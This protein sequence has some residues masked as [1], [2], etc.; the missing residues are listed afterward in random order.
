MRHKAKK[1][2]QTALFIIAVG[3]WLFPSGH[4]TD[5]VETPGFSVNQS[6]GVVG[7]GWS[8]NI[9]A[10]SW[11]GS[12]IFS[13][14]EG[15]STGQKTIIG[16]SIVMML[17]FFAYRLVF[18]PVRR[19]KKNDKEQDSVRFDSTEF[20]TYI[21]EKVRQRTKELKLANE[22]LKE[23]LSG[24]PI[25]KGGLHH[26][27][28]HLNCLYGVSRLVEQPDISLGDVFQK[29]AHLLQEAY[30][31]P[32]E[33]SVRITFDGIKY[34]TDN[35]EKSESSQYVQIKIDNSYL[36]SIEVYCLSG[37][38]QNKERDFS[39]EED[40]L[41]NAIAGR[42]GSFAEQKRYAQ[43]LRLFQNL[44][45]QSSDSIFII[46]PQWGRLV[47]VNQT[48]CKMLGY[49]REELL[50]MTIKDIEE[51]ISDDSS[52]RQLVNDLHKSSF[53][54]KEG[55]HK[56]KDNTSFFV[57]TCLNCVTQKNEELI[58]ALAR[59]ITERKEA[60]QKQMRLI[61][62]LKESTYKVESINK[63]LKD[64]AYIISHDLKA[65]LRGIKTVTG[66][67]RDD[68][69]DKLDKDG[70]EQLDLLLSRVERMH[71]LIDGVLQYSRA[72]REESR[73]ELVNLNDLVPEAID[74]VLPP[75]NIEIS[76]ENELPTIKCDRIRVFQVFQ[77]L[78]SNAVKYMDKEHGTIKV[79][80]EQ[81]G[82]C[83]KFGVS[84]NGPG[85]EEKHYERI[86]RMFQ[87]LTPKDKFESTGV[88]LTVVK[89][90]IQLYGGKVWVESKLGQ[91][92]TFFFTLPMDKKATEETEIT[93]DMKA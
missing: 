86:F 10:S 67:L 42:L 8:G 68:Y 85:I 22:Q 46:E 71:N 5:L 87:T 37:E 23:E 33:T 64:F 3:V 69:S 34:E 77:N 11:F 93:T 32:D 89:K 53:L 18:R 27:L 51:D 54:T 66:W 59:D 28:K 24:R 52:W 26:R 20:E 81:E 60:E 14:F 36:G 4:F 92:S 57:E 78:L 6:C 76:I 55:R 31:Q 40:D 13:L 62:K 73:E 70:K 84:D 91:G 63:E 15:Y 2:I 9:V 79:N 16:L 29:T 30:Q 43:R 58:I 74:M 61:E 12:K 7:N 45:D 25:I 38:S 41:L 21:K 56:R 47:D 44:M 75:G 65:P 72:G 48:S 1:S 19:R 39:K 83:W 80:C 49:S 82:G 17:G 50:S 35:F 90:I 88:G